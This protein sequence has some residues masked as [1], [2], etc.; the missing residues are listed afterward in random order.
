MLTLFAVIIPILFTD[1][2]NPVLL[3][4]VIYTLGSRKPY[5]NAVSILLGWFVVYFICGIGLAIG[6]DTITHFLDNPRPADF[7]IETVVSVLLL[8]LAIHMLRGK[9]GKRKK[10]DFGE[11]DTVSPVSA[12]LIGA[13]M[14]LIGMPFAIPYFAV[15]DQILKADLN[16]MGGT[17]VLFVYNVLYILPFGVLI[18]IRHLSREKSG[19]LFNKLSG[20]MDRVS[21]VLIPVMMILIALNLLTDAAVYFT[22][23]R[24][25]L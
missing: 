11:A 8:W 15:I 6:L 9:E 24:I 18:I 20:C 1:I 19:I 22:T 13:T 23:G 7:Y 14:N 2:I 3:A 12:F 16:W 25:L 5:L 10:K 4:G 17:L 21:A